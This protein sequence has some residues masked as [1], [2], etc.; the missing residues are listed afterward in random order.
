MNQRLYIVTLEEEKTMGTNFYNFSSC[1]NFFTDL[2][3]HLIPV[4]FTFFESVLF[5]LTF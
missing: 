1:Y 3:R 2:S 4:I 5:P